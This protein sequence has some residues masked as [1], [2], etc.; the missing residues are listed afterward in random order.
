MRT[1][2][3]SACG[4]FYHLIVSL[5]LLMVG[6]LSVVAGRSIMSV[7]ERG[8]NTL[9][10]PM[11]LHALNRRRLVDKLKAVDSL[12]NK[13]SFVLLVGGESATRYDSDH[14]PVFR[15]ESY[16]HWMFGVQEPDFCGGVSVP[17]GTSYLFAPKLPESYAVWMG[18]LHTT[19]EIRQ[20]YAVDRV[21]W[22]DDMNSTL[23]S[24]DLDTLLTLNGLNTDSGKTSQ[25]AQ[26]NGRQ[27]FAVNNTILHP[28]ISELRVFKT[29]MELGVMRYINKISSEAHKEVMRKTRVGMKEYQMES[30]FQHYCYYTGGARFMSYT[31]ICA[32]GNN[33]AVLHYGHAGAPNDKTIEDGDMLLFDMGSEYYCYASDITCSF[34]ANGS[35]TADQKIIYNAVLNASRAVMRSVKPGVAWTDMHLLAERIQLEEL[36]KHGLLVG[37]VDQMMIHRLGAIFMPHGLGHFMGIDTHDVGGYQAWTPERS[38]LPGL[39]SLRTARILEKGMVLTIEPGIYFV[40][41]LLDKALNDSALSQFL[42]PDQISRFRSFGGVRI[43]DDIVVTEDGLELLTHVPRSVEEIES[44]MRGDRTGDVSSQVKESAC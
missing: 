25:E 14:E 11:E 16:F 44:L 29:D 13:T 3:S 42:V 20:R 10:V 22:F 19:D 27:E 6:R 2:L 43:E 38:E 34:P 9:Q 17:D 15:Q 18:R 35:F 33:S 40:H 39:K 28:I 12:Q 1:S 4:M 30:V 21:I 23:K 32:S 5:L 37:D 8:P 36:K 7:F 31:C 41:H 24:L 26:F